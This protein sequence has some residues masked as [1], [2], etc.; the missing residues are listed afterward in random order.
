ML[1]VVHAL[2]EGLSD[3]GVLEQPESFFDDDNAW[4][5]GVRRS[6]VMEDIVWAVSS[7]GLTAAPV[8]TPGEPVGSV[9]FENIDPCAGEMGWGGWDEG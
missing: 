2:P 5:G 9:R 6:V 1:Q 8:A 3:L 7:A 4:C